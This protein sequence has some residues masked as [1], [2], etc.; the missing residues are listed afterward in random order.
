V[1][2]ALP[3]VMRKLLLS[4]GCKLK[5]CAGASTKAPVRACKHAAGDDKTEIDALCVTVWAMIFSFNGHESCAF[6]SCQSN[7]IGLHYSFMIRMN[8]RE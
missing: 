2:H 8:R 7:E 5:A 3:Q 1:I 4:F 6:A